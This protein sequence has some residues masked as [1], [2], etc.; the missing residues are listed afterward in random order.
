MTKLLLS[1]IFI[2][3]S[4]RRNGIIESDGMEMG[5]VSIA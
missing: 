4:F 1:Q 2:I 3:R 5:F